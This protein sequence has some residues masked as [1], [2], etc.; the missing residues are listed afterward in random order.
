[1]KLTRRCFGWLSSPPKQW[2]AHAV[3]KSKLGRKTG[4]LDDADIV[5]LNQAL[6]VFFGLATAA[7][8]RSGA[9]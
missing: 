6:L 4:R 2:I 3:T 5:R 1:M 8:I 7:R 9:K